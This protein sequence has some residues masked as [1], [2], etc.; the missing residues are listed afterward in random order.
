MG[1]G[2]SIGLTSAGCHLAIG[3]LGAPIGLI[4]MLAINRIYWSFS[5]GHVASHG[6]YLSFNTFW[7]TCNRKLGSGALLGRIIFKTCQLSRL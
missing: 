4:L 5:R 1:L 6:V 3:Y 2:G 7:L